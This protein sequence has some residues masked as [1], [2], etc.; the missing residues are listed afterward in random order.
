ML[1]NSVNRI[2]ELQVPNPVFF[3][4]VKTKD[5]SVRRDNFVTENPDSYS[6]AG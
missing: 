4:A 2:P 3:S 6:R 5:S 1:H